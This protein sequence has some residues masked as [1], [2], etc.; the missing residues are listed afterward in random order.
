MGVGEVELL[1]G[2]GDG[3]VAQ[4]ALFFQC[5]WLHEGT[6]AGENAFVHA[7]QEYQR[8]FQ[9]LSAVDGHQG[10]PVLFAFVV[11]YVVHESHFFQEF[12]EAAFGLLVGEIFRHGEEFA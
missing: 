8:K 4:A 7:R 11:V 10:D 3:H 1:L 5:R 9:A 6:D 12:G 2:A